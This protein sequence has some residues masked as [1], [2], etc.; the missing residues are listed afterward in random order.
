ML[1]E[2][3]K[4]NPFVEFGRKFI[5][6]S[7]EKHRTSTEHPLVPKDIKLMKKIFGNIEKYEFQFLSASCYVFN[8]LGWKK[9]FKIFDSIFMFLDKILWY[10]PFLRPMY[11]QVLI[12]CYKN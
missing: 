10:I 7:H 9:L 4:F 8:L 11:W 5:K 12:K 2:P 1:V 3:Q 6:N